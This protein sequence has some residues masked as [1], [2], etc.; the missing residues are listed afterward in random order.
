[1][2][3]LLAFDWRP[4]VGYFMP[5]PLGMILILAGLI[6]LWLP[7]KP[8]WGRWLVTAGF[9]LIYAGGNARLGDEALHGMEAKVPPLAESFSPE[10]PPATIVVL[11]GG[12]TDDLSLPLTSQ[13]SSETLARVAEALRLH[14]T[15]PDSKLLF[16]GKGPMH[17]V[18]AEVMAKLARELGVAPESILLESESMN[19]GEQAL[20]LRR[21]L[22]ADEPFVL[23]TSAS[24]MARA[25]A[26]FRQAGLSPI[27]A[28]TAHQTSRSP[29]QEEH[30]YHG[31]LALPGSYGAK[32][33]ERAIYEQL[34]AWKTPRQVEEQL[35]MEAK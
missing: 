30:W 27:P 6:G 29:D 18:E 13:V 26:A 10:K 32:T 16:S 19:T 1:M 11:G 17:Q 12:V 35:K 4:V 15:W 9:L 7:K 3:L 21:R 5:L 25:A 31:W 33:L 8:R 28:P 24:H 2:Q 14:R 23:V 34:G 22:P 20:I